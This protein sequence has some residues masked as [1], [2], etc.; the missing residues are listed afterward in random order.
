MSCTVAQ[1]TLE[2]YDGC[3]RELREV[4]GKKETHVCPPCIIPIYHELL[5][6]QLIL[7]ENG[8]NDAVYL[9]CADKV[10]DRRFKSQLNPIFQHQHST[11]QRLRSHSSHTLWADG[12][13]AAMTV[14]LFRSSIYSV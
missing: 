9:T 8:M 3:E 12:T 14:T 11:T 4:E 10:L 5:L 6:Q 13:S 1:E 7:Q 2:R